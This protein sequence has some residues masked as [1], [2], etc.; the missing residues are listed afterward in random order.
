MKTNLAA[1]PIALL[2]LVGCGGSI[3]VVRTGPIMDPYADDCPLEFLEDPPTRQYVELAEMTTKV[4]EVPAA[5]PI[6]QNGATRAQAA[7]SVLHQKACQLGAD[8]VIVIR[9]QVI[10]E[11]GHMLVAGT[12]IRYLPPPPDP[13]VPNNQTNPPSP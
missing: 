11:D 10:N 9:A 1:G 3:K 7:D 4:V 13:P 8:A 12:A 6:L 2:F 5:G